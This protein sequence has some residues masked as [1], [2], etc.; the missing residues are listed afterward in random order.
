MLGVIDEIMEPGQLIDFINRESFGVVLTERDLF[1]WVCQA[2]EDVKDG[3]ENRAE[4]VHG[5]WNRTQRRDQPDEWRPKTEPECQNVLWPTIQSRLSNLNIVGVEEHLVRAD[6]ADFWVEK[7]NSSAQ[8]FRVIVELKTARED[9]GHRELIEPIESQLW[10]QYLC[11]NDC[12][13]G[14]FI[15]LWFKDE[16]R[17]PHPRN[18]GTLDEFEQELS[19]FK[20]QVENSHNIHLA[21]YAIDMTTS[22]RIR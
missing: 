6:R 1:E 12:K 21:C 22:A 4:Q 17:Y 20:E 5:Y 16:S 14:I 8:P 2:I 15:V 19:R 10:Q 18:W 9:Y 3:L 11:P 13:Y 7:P